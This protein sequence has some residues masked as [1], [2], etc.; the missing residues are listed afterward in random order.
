MSTNRPR[1]LSTFR[2]PLLAMTGL[3]A[4]C[5]GASAQGGPEQPGPTSPASAS[6]SVAPAGSA[7]AAASVSP[8][9][10]APA[11]SPGGPPV[12][13]LQAGMDTP[14]TLEG[15]APAKREVKTPCGYFT[16]APSAVIEV[17]EGGL[18]S[19]GVF[20]AFENGGEGRRFLFAKA[21]FDPA[22]ATLTDTKTHQCL[23]TSYVGRLPAGRTGVWM[24]S[25]T[26]DVALPFK[27]VAD[28]PTDPKSIQSMLLLA[29]KVTSDLP[30]E[31]RWLSLHY[32]RLTELV[33]EREVTALQGTGQT[34]QALELRRQLWLTVPEELLV[35]AKPEGAK[36]FS[37]LPRPLTTE[38]PLLVIR[39]APG[40]LNAMTA[41]GQFLYFRTADV[42]TT[43]RPAKVRVDTQRTFRLTPD[44]PQNA[45]YTTPQMQPMAD[46]AKQ[47]DA[48]YTPCFEQHF[49]PEAIS[50]RALSSREILTYGIDGAK[51][52]VA[53]AKADAAC[54]TEKAAWD[55]ARGALRKAQLEAR[56]ARHA[57]VIAEIAARFAK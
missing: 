43:A 16:K 36:A 30:V 33:L 41:D 4:A 18:Q 35:F 55:T 1:N 34:R 13:K 29:S 8:A 28:A 3:L 48:K 5:G 6:A 53:E 31:K 42:L 52:R 15:T 50:D 23:P 37:A 46:Q 49:K 9:G 11:A 27:L 40:V 32:P 19:A 51:Q 56:K 39:V 22:T 57:E 12:V 47:A 20:L 17:P 21:D 45:D 7:S 54:K 38:E 44:D 24:G 26:Q 10:T 14:V 25:E 2:H